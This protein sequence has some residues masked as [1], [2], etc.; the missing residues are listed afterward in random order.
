MRG[1]FNIYFLSLIRYVK[2]NIY[3]YIYLSRWKMEYILYVDESDNEGP[4]YSNFYGGILV[5]STHLKL[6]TAI[7]E[8]KKA[9]LGISSEIKWQ[10]VSKQFLDK[11]IELMDTL[12]D[13][14]ENDLVKIRIM[15]THNYTEPVGLTMEQ[16]K[17]EFL[18]LYYQFLKHAFGL[19]YSN[20]TGSDT[21]VRIYFDELPVNSTNSSEFKEYIHSLQYNKD[22]REAKISIKRE[23][24]TEI[25][26]KEHVLLQYMDI[27]LGSMYFRLNNFHKAI[28]EGQRK[29]G[30]RTIAKEIL[31]KHINNRIRKIYPNFNIGISTGLKGDI[32][33]RWNHPYRH[34]LFESANSRVNEGY[35]KK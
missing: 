30:N 35:T 21:N 12:F 8:D 9:T 11:Y 18:L 31:Y 33:N 17:N 15:F 29:R 3:I 5:R 14:I 4:L 2:V 19:I 23:N 13:L 27:V 7:L 22:F 32:K 10:R 1:A 34:W 20:N 6:V 28:P 16:R 24:I 26:S 25:D